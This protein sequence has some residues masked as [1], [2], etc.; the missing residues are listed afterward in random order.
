VHVGEDDGSILGF[1]GGR[2]DIMGTYAC[3]TNM[4]ESW[5]I[6]M[7]SASLAESHM[8]MHTRVGMSAT[9]QKTQAPGTLK[10]FSAANDIQLG[11]R[12]SHVVGNS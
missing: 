12:A 9:P 1:F 6:T 7:G 5:G 2:K 3:Q 10:I 11:I 4:L 8:E